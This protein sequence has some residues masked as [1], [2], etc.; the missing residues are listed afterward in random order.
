MNDA[1]IMALVIAMSFEA[2]AILVFALFWIAL[3]L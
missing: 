3:W 2:L 1:L